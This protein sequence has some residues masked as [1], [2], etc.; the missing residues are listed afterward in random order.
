[1]ATTA[2]NNNNAA[3]PDPDAPD[4]RS[5]EAVPDR[6]LNRIPGYRVF[7]ATKNLPEE[8]M[9][10]VRW[11]HGHYWDSGKS[12]GEIGRLI[13]YDG[14]NVSKIFH[15]KYEGDMAAVEKAITR[16]RRLAEE[17]ASI[18]RAPYMET[19][20]YRDIEECCQAALTYQKIV[21]I[22]GESQ[23]GKSAALRHYEQKHNHGE[24]LMVEMPVGGALVSFCTALAERLRMNPAQKLALLQANIMRSITA[25]NLLIIDEASRVFQSTS[26]AGRTLR[27]LDFIRALHDGTGCAI[28][29]CGTNVLRDQMQ[30]R[31][32]AKF[33]NQF[34][35]RC[36]LRRQLPD[37]PLREDL[38]AFAAHYGLAPAGGDA[39]ALQ[40]QVAREHGLGVWLTTLTA[41]ARNATRQN[42]EMTWDHVLKA[43]AFFQRMEQPRPAA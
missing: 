16:Y 2:D 19:Q 24:T 43:H 31:A 20:L 17:R 7:E 9:L 13:G 26:Y 27:T 10:A 41:A 3:A 39:L 11:L 30:D 28:V 32:M 14:G 8:Q 5:R 22:Y 21:Y 33:L 42:K 1:M 35:R 23:V 4:H 15:A 25:R 38:N 29:V 6:S 36:L 37:V 12:L 40:T 34:N 18:N